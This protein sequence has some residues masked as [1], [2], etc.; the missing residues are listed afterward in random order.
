MTNATVKTVSLAT[1]PAFKGFGGGQPVAGDVM[2]VVNGEIVA[3]ASGKGKNKGVMQAR[4]MVAQVAYAY[5][6]EV[7]VAAE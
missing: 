3:W 1:L 5:N 6:T 2:V 7:V 4:G